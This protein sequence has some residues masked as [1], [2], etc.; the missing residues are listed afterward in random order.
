M[1]PAAP[2]QPR[3]RLARAGDTST[4]T[5]TWDQAV[6]IRREWLGIGLATSAADRIATEEAL[7]RPYARL[8][9]RRPEFVLVES[10]RAAAAV[11]SGVPNHHEL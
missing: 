4:I 3:A 9:R 7:S 2:S 8:H 10:P 1:T 5:S 11:V 6:G